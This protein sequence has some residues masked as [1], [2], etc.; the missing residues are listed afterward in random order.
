MLGIIFQALSWSISYQFMAKADMKIYA[1]NETIK[2]VI[3]LLLNVIGYLL[4]GLDGLGIAFTISYIFYFV[5]VLIVSK[6]KYNFYFRKTLIELFIITSLLLISV[7]VAVLLI[8][9]Y[10]K[11]IISVFLLLLSL[12]YSF[13]ELNKRLAI[14]EII[15]NKIVNK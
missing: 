13:K 6:I 11:Y 3:V 1:I 7:F 8:E 15:K 10:V 9:S 2:N 12:I 4:W 14:S 5:Q